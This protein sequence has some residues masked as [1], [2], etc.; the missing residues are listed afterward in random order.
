MTS[1]TAGKVLLRATGKNRHSSPL[2]VL[3]NRSRFSDN[4]NIRGTPFSAAGAITIMTNGLDK[5]SRTP[6]VKI[7]GST[8]ERNYGGSAGGALYVKGELTVHDS[9][10]EGNVVYPWH[11]CRSGCHA[12]RVGGAAIHTERDYA[13]EYRNTFPE[14]AV[15][16]E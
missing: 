10:F 6:V 11:G 16:S 4:W 7:Q 12:F 3:L 5:L 15:P 14:Q 9:L 1:G 8:F 13:L 2:T